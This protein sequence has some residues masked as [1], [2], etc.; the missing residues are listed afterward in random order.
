[1][2]DMNASVIPER[3]ASADEAR[4][5]VRG[6]GAAVLAGVQDEPTAL[7]LGHQ[8]MGEK[9]VRIGTQ[10][11]VTGHNETEQAKAVAAQPVDERGRKRAFSVAEERMPPHNDGYAFGDLAPDHLFLWCERPSVVGGESF[12][13]DTSR[14]IDLLAKDPLNA[15]LAEFCRTVGVDHSEPNYPQGSS[16]P[17]V[18]SSATGRFQGRYHPYLS[19]VGGPTEENDRRFVRRWE[20]AV[21]RARDSGP[22]FRLEAGDMLCID[23]YRMLHGRDAHSDPKRRLCSI[24]GWSTDAFAIPSGP[25]DIVNPRLAPVAE[26][27]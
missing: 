13:I 14:L 26:N 7:S 9:A 16:H 2:S 23:N 22:M 4:A 21:L 25:L 1:M 15:D 11:D 18:R 12:L 3:V 19:P 8:V 17:L 6:R 10:I 5:L 24:W 27:P 20:E